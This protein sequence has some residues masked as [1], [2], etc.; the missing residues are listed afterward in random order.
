MRLIDNYNIFLGTL[1]EVSRDSENGV[2]MIDDDLGFLIEFKNQS[3]G[4]IEKVKIK[5]KAFD[6]VSLISLNES[7]TIEEIAKNTIL[8]IVY[9]NENYEANDNSFSPSESMDKFAMKLKEL[10]TGKDSEQL[11]QWDKLDLYPHKFDTTGYIDTF[12]KKVYTIDLK[13]FNEEFFDIIFN[14]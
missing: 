3:E 2:S 1:T 6:S 7:L 13:V 4:N 12:Y 14:E 10:S 11:E 5:N 8:I 9:N